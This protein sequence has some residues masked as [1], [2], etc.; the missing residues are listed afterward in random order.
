M[1]SDYERVF[2]SVLYT[3]Q[4]VAGID[5]LNSPNCSADGSEADGGQDLGRTGKWHQQ[6]EHST[7]CLVWVNYLN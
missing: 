7:A 6:Q 5:G 1:N 4:T 2:T 3:S